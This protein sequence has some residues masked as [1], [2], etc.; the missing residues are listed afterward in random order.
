MLDLQVLLQIACCRCNGSM[1]ATLKCEGEGLGDGADVNALVSL[2]C[3]ACQQVNQ[4]IF[5]PEDGRVI[6][7]MSELRIFRIPEP[8]LN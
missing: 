3:P 1:E 7:V 8:S 4:V 2:S 6:D 5:R